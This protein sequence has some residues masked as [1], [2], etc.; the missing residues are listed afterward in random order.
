MSKR[1]HGLINIPERAG[2]LDGLQH[3]PMNIHEPRPRRARIGGL[4][5]SL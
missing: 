3:D 4:G 2:R 1:Q 5:A